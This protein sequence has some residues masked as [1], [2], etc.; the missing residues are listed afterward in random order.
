MWPNG[1]APSPDL[2]HDYEPADAAGGSPEPRV[3]A[4]QTLRALRFKASASFGRAD[5]YSQK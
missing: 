2:L 4:R 1:L 3:S 5:R